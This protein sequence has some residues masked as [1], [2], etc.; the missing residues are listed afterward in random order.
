VRP[1][2]KRVDTCAAEFATT[3]PYMYSTYEDE[4]RSAKPTDDARR[5]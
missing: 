3:T 2:Y 1:V 4:V 5:S